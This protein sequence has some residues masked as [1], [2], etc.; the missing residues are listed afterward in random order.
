[1][2]NFWEILLYNIA[3]VGAWHVVDFVLCVYGSP[4][5]FDFRRK[6]YQMFKWEKNGKWYVKYLKIKLWKDLV[7]THVGKQGFSFHPLFRRFPSGNL[8][9]RM[10]SFPVRVLRGA[11]GDFQSLPAGTDFRLFDS[12]GQPALCGDPAV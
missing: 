10:G 2:K 12:A 8:P 9:G 4:S 6:R 5:W 7:P 11:R 3:F 1:M